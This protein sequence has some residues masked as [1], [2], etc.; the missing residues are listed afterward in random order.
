MNSPAETSTTIWSR[1][2][3]L[4]SLSNALLFAGFHLL[5]PTLPLFIEAYGA[6]ST[7][8]GLIV[9]GFTFSAIGIRLFTSAGILRW[10]H[11][12]FLQIG[13]LICI[14][15]MASYYFTSQVSATLLVRLAHGMGFGIASTL[16]ATLAVGLI[17]ANRRGEGMGYFSLGST[18]VMVLAPLVGLWLYTTFLAK[19][20]FIA[21]TILQALS[22]IIVYFISFEEHLSIQTHTDQASPFSV[23][24]VLLPCIFSF[25]LGICIGGVMSFITLLAQEQHFAN[26]GLFFLVSMSCVFLVRT[27]SGRVYDQFGAP[28]VIAPASLSLLLSMFSLFTGSTSFLVAAVFYGIGLG[29]LF[30]ALQTWV[31]QLAP[32]EKQSTASATFYNAVDT[33]IGGGS[34]ILGYIVEGQ[35]YTAVYF[36]TSCISFSFFSSYLLYLVY[37]WR[38]RT[39]KETQVV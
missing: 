14:L 31:I 4:I 7:Q 19:G 9:G 33:G 6:T 8:I 16:F 26:P 39:L 21:G 12:H 23:S 27:F 5:L 24:Q 18:F 37:L 25:L 34:I 15:S 11:R 13:L 22:F 35:S 10:G 17:P 20:L 3:I 30:P 1:N 38:K 36:V 2:F 28:W 29:A 32:Q